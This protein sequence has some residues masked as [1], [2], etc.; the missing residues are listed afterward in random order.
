M[1]GTLNASV[2][3]VFRNDNDGLPWENFAYDG[4]EDTSF[5]TRFQAFM[6][7]VNEYSK[8]KGFDKLEAMC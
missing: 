2:S 8:R 1:P 3:N 7:Q 4:Q 6:H 5:D